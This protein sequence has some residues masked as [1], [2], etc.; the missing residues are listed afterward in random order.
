MI[1]SHIYYLQTIVISNELKFCNVIMCRRTVVF[2]NFTFVQY[3]SF[4]TR[5]PLGAQH[6]GHG[7]HS[8]G[9]LRF[10]GLA[11]PLPHCLLS[12]DCGALIIGSGK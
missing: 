1:K 12:F 5:L 3:L 4:F 8:V 11:T 2:I 9:Q 7:T 6:G 10:T